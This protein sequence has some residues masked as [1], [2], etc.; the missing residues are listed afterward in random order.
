VT[1]DNPQL[2]IIIYWRAPDFS[3][4]SLALPKIV[5]QSIRWR[6]FMCKN[7]N[8]KIT[9]KIFS[10]SPGTGIRDQNSHKTLTV[11]ATLTKTLTVLAT[12]AT[13]LTTTLAT[14]LAKTLAKRHTLTKY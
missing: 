14:T 1:P 4:L 2:S 13:T 11:L 5:V 8:F 7:L 3:R 6:R 9:V 12:L 10:M